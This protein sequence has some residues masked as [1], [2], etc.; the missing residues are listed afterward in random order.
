MAPS[1]EREHSPGE[2]EYLSPASLKAPPPP[3]FIRLLSWK[4]TAQKGGSFSPEHLIETQGG[5]SE[6]DVLQVCLQRHQAEVR[7][8]QRGPWL[9]DGRYHREFA[10][11]N[12][13]VSFQSLN[14]DG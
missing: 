7:C 3:D 8:E 5:Y 11:L 14:S 4:L 1:E 10:G 13:T 2:A 12:T 9:S 6:T